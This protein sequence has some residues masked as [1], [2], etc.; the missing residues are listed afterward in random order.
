[1]S[2]NLS[3]RVPGASAG[4]LIEPSSGNE[5]YTSVSRLVWD[6]SAYRYPVA[7]ALGAAVGLLAGWRHGAA[8]GQWLPIILMALAGGA[9]GALAMG[10]FGVVVRRG[11]A[12][13]ERHRLDQRRV[14]LQGM[15][16]TIESAL[17][18][19]AEADQVETAQAHLGTLHLLAGDAAEALKHLKQADH[20]GSRD[21]VLYNNAGVA[22]ARQGRFDKAYKALRTALQ[23]A[24]REVAIEL[25]LCLLRIRMDDPQ[26]ALRYLKQAGERAERPEWRQLQAALEGLAA[27][28]ERAAG[29]LQEMLAEAAQPDPLLLNTLGV[30]E[31]S[32][33]SLDRA[34][35]AFEQALLAHPR[36]AAAHGNRGVVMLLNHRLKPALD[37]LRRARALDPQQEQVLCNLGVVWHR[38]GQYERSKEAF[39]AALQLAPGLYEAHHNLSE[40]Y[41]EQEHW[42]EA[43][44]AAEQALRYRPEGAAARN[45]QGCAL[46]RLARYDEAAEQFEVASRDDA[47]K[48][49]ALHNQGLVYAVSGRVDPAVDALHQAV[50]LEPEAVDHHA[51]LAYAYHVNGHLREAYRSYQ[52]LLTHGRTDAVCYHMGLCD[53]ALERYETA[54]DWLDEALRLNPKLKQAFFPLG[55]AH[56]ALDKLDKALEYWQKGMELEPESDE[57][58]SNLGLAYYRY[59]RTA[60][61]L[62]MLR[63]AYF[64]RPDEPA[65]CNNLALAYAQAQRYDRAADFFENAVDLT[66]E[67]VVARCNLG[68]AYY[69]SGRV[70]EALEEWTTASKV[71]PTYY[72]RRQRQDLKNTFDD[73]GLRALDL[74]WQTRALPIGPRRSGFVHRFVTQL[75][76]LP[77]HVLVTEEMGLDAE[78]VSQWRDDKFAVVL[79]PPA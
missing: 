26:S 68:L 49:T 21:P 69:L 64:L 47:L 22:L 1:M 60:E 66:P 59:G 51:A 44:L 70:E 39:R 20:E 61:A 28:P 72:L 6:S 42:E 55:S 25:N 43:L 24:P 65:F 46:L 15:M 27:H 62:S 71:D 63:R 10:A 16:A 33:G 77:W 32:R 67:S 18:D 31:G 52:E 38:L 8:G 74:N 58:L 75:P 40:A 19:D 7:V 13:R 54:V 11:A 14:L 9:A 4:T 29:M 37:A 53:Y 56:A 36:L 34:M 12:R 48:A 76:D 45:N 35:A 50:E 30:I 2:I 78:V 79:R 73:V 5:V 57:L 17:A 3:I 23:V 41:L